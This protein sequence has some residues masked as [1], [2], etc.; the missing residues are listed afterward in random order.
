MPEIEIE[1]DIVCSECREHLTATGGLHKGSP[2]FVVEP[3]ATCLEKAK[4]KGDD[5]GYARC[6]DK[7][8]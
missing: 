7:I 3:C 1:I 6:M 5:E 4:D 8:M 2:I